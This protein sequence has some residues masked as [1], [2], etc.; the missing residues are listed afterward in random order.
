MSIQYALGQLH[1]NTVKA[2][3][4]LDNRQAINP[5]DLISRER[6][7][8]LRQCFAVLCVPV[9]GYNDQ[10]IENQKVGIGSR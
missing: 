10:V 3:M 1:G 2:A 4:L 7:C 9:S 6:L 5:L 8:Q